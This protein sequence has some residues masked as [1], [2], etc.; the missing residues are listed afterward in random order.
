MAELNADHLV[1]V[2]RLTGRTKDA[3]GVWNRGTQHLLQLRKKIFLYCFVA[4]S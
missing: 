2:P 4:V 1:R 3:F